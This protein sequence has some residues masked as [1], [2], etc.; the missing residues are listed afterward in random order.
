[1]TRRKLVTVLSIIYIVIGFGDVCY[2]LYLAS[3]PSGAIFDITAVIHGILTFYIGFQ[4]LQLHEFGRKLAIGLAYVQVVIYVLVSFSSLYEI[5]STKKAVVVAGIAFRDKLIYPIGN[6]YF[7]PGFWL[8]VTIILLFII[9]FLSQVKT[10]QLFTSQ[11]SSD[12]YK[13]TISDSLQK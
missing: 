7:V 13:E 3:L 11:N 1:M 2:F 5:L 6:P 10:K 8:S 12:R 9:V 4:L